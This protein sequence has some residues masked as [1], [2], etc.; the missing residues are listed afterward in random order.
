MLTL[1]QVGYIKTQIQRLESGRYDADDCLW[2]IASAADLIAPDAE[3]DSSSR[4]YI[5]RWI[6]GFKQ[7]FS[8]VM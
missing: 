2:R 8:H 5:Q 4:E 7:Q 1:S 6:D 3:L